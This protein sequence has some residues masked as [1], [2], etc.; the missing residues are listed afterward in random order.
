VDL[1]ARELEV[2]QLVARGWSNT[3]IADELG[4]VEGTVKQHVSSIY[5]KLNV[6]SRAEA[7][8]WAWQ[9][10]PGESHEQR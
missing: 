4:I 7:V 5:T 3:R 6:R 2:L 9:H 8:A 10:N 1:T